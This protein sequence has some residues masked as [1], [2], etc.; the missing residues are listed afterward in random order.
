M[1]LRKHTAC[2][3][4]MIIFWMG[5]VFPVVA[6]N[7]K[8]TQTNIRHTYDPKAP[9]RLDHRVAMGTS[10]ATL[11]LKVS[12]HGNAGN[13]PPSLTY[14]VRDGY[15]NS[16]VLRNNTIGSQQLIKQEDRTYFYRLSLPVDEESQ[17]V[18]VYATLSADGAGAPF[19]FDIPLE[20][21]TSFPLTDLVTMRPNEDVPLF[22]HY[23]EKSDSFRIVSVYRQAPTAFVYFYPYDFAP[24][25]PPMA[26]SGTESQQNLT[27]D[28]LFS[29][30]LN[31]PLTFADQGLYFVQTDTSSLSGISFRIEDQYYP[32]LVRAETLIEP[33]R[34]ISTSEEMEQ[35]E[36]EDKKAALD[37]YW[38]KVT[39]SQER[40]K[41]V[42]R[43]Y[44][45]QVT[46][47]NRLFTT[48][49]EGWKTG[50]GMVYILYGTPDK[51]FREGEREVWV[52]DA[53]RDLSDM[54]FSFVKVK[55]IYTDAHYNLV[56][57][58]DY[59]KFWFRNIDLWRKGLKTMR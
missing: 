21:N 59:K 25:P 5:L 32:R 53:D 28:S 8:P 29:V 17:Y 2:L 10:E 45:R 15:K 19:R 4:G 55:N 50:Q 42:I 52:Y 48:Y 39:R 26:V 57:D 6:Q 44:Y 56:P 38:M 43:N 33:L 27:I 14:E 11:F 13:T 9:V 49:K 18:F 41:T 47:A 35:M 7:D 22:K 20:T 54:S 37:K 51:V 36:E 58:E 24:N 16:K 31:E 30:S 40:A 3:L 23:I 1:N 46:E 12:L 34:Y